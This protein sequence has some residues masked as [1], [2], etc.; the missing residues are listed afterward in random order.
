M[1]PHYIIHTLAGL[2]DEFRCQLEC[3][4][5]RLCQLRLEPTQCTSIVPALEEKTLEE[6]TTHISHFEDAVVLYILGRRS[7]LYHYWMGAASLR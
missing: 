2:E 3:W 1:T 7:P 4:T 6:I 5:Q